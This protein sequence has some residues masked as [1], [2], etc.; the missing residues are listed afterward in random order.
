MRIFKPATEFVG[1]TNIKTYVDRWELT[2][3]GRLYVVLK[4]GERFRSDYRGVG[5][6]REGENIVEQVEVVDYCLVC[7]AQLKNFDA[8]EVRLNCDTTELLPPSISLPPLE[9]QGCFRVGAGCAKK[10]RAAWA[11][12]RYPQ[13][14]K[15]RAGKS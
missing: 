3:G 9:D 6:L 14:I 12:G 11:D 15:L 8:V 2:D 7:E 10:V 1:R 13:L 4:N 5:E